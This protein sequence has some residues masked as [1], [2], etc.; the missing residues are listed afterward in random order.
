[1]LGAH[2]H[3]FDKLTSDGIDIENSVTVAGSENDAPLSTLGARPGRTGLDALRQEIVGRRH[4]LTSTKRQ[5]A[6]YYVEHTFH[7]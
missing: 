2:A 1:M 4:R 6:N 5:Q 3:D 7:L